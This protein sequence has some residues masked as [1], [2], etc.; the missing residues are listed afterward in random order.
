MAVPLF[1]GVQPTTLSH[2]YLRL[3]EDDHIAPTRSVLTI[4]LREESGCSAPK[5]FH[6]PR[7]DCLSPR[8]WGQGSRTQARL[9]QELFLHGQDRGAQRHEEFSEGASTAVM[10]AFGSMHMSENKQTGLRPQ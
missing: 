9:D 8:C 2:N 3:C 10:S 6:C 5:A 1:A 4:Q 7:R